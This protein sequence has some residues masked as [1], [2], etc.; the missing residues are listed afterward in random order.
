MA[1]SDRST[2][3]L[4][5][6]NEPKHAKGYC[7]PHYRRFRRTG[8]PLSDQDRVILGLIPAPS[9]YCSVDG[10][11]RPP[12]HKKMCSRHYRNLRYTGYAKP[13]TEWTVNESL[14]RI[15]WNVTNSGC[16]EWRGA[17]RGN[18]YGALSLSRYGLDEAPVHR[19][20]YERFIGL[21]P[22]GLIIRHKCDNPPCCNPDHLEVGTHWDNMQDMVERGRHWNTKKTQC[23][24]GH[25]ISS[26]ESVYMSPR[27]GGKFARVCK[28]CHARQVKASKAKRDSGKIEVTDKE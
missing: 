16:W 19:L 12:T 27:P 23:K 4:D 6:C 8:D 5:H 2:C 22:D 26:P 24:W 10:C 3:K 20:M 13:K 11:D 17:T 21:I 18:G 7:D 9:P 15:G 28:V 25:D 14:D 1:T